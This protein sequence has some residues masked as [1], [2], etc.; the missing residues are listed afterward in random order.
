MRPGHPQH[1]DHKREL[2]AT[3]IQDGRPDLC[4]R[5]LRGRFT[6]NAESESSSRT[7]TSRPADFSD[8][9]T[10]RDRLHVKIWRSRPADCIY[11]GK[12][13]GFQKSNL[14]ISRFSVRVRGGSLKRHI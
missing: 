5:D 2:A 6:R 8:R 3:S 14:L 4:D 12:S 11:S 7:S 10:E 13:A 1:A 9:L